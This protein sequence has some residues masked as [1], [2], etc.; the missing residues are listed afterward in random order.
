MILHLLKLSFKDIPQITAVLRN[1]QKK[2]GTF[3]FDYI[4]KDLNCIIKIMHRDIFK[5]TTDFLRK[6]KHHRALLF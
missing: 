4:L 3:S 6:N 1:V 2:I 5:Q